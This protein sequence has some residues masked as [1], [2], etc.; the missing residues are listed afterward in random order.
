MDTVPSPAVGR[1]VRAPGVYPMSR[2]LRHFGLALLLGLAVFVADPAPAAAGWMGFRNDTGA[3]L[4]LQ[5]TV[6]SRAGR[7]QKLFANETVRDT[8]P[9]AG[10]SRTFAIYDAG[11]PDKP[12][13]SGRFPAPT[14]S[15]NVLY[16]I[17]SDGRGGLV[18]EAVK[19]PAG[20]LPKK[21]NPKR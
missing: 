16:V 18:V 13:H 3:T 21:P 7:P 6:A 1:V 11:K 2:G 12:L 10:A 15:E 5:E 17:K 8:P 20:G 19:L 14:A 4:V 9:V